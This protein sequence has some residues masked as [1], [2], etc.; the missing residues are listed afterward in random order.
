MSKFPSPHQLRLNF[1]HDVSWF[2]LTIEAD[3]L[4]LCR[5]EHLHLLIQVLRVHLKLVVCVLFEP[6][7]H[8]FQLSTA[9]E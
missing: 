4:V 9:A 7:G 3:A 5:F 8:L 2:L 1:I 6:L